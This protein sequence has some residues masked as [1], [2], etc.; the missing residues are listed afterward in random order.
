MDHLSDC[1]FRRKDSYARSNLLYLRKTILFVFALAG[2][3][4]SQGQNQR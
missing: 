3:L 1:E 4:H 2:L